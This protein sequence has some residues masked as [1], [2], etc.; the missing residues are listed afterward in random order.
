MSKPSHD[1]VRE[2]IASIQSN[3]RFLVATHVR[4]DGDAIGSVLS[5][6]RVLQRLGKTADPYCQDPVPAA[7]E[8]LPAVQS[9][10]NNATRPDLYDV[11]VL[12]DCGEFLRVGEALAESIRRIPFQ[13]SI[14]HHISYGS[15]G[16]VFWNKT[17]AS[18]TCEMLYELCQDLPLTIDA[19]L[20]TTLYTGLLSDTGSFRFSNT[21]QRVLEI[22]ANLVAAGAR[23]A[24]IA[25]QVYDSA[26]VQSLW[27]LAKVLA[28]L[29]FYSDDHLATAEMSQKMFSETR[30]APADAEGFVN[31]L[32]SVGTV[33]MAIL[34]R[35]GTDGDV[36][37]SL[38][39]K[40]DIDVADFAR[41]LG[42]GG[43]RNAAAFHVRGELGAT[44]AR[45]TGEALAFLEQETWKR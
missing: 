13:I 11:A 2:L 7:Y 29:A 14:D 27:L 9:I 15:F 30:A 26:S 6:T 3:Q 41:R 35:E 22:A 24:F 20:A 19:D 18:S 38:R 1:V 36:H 31:F 42:G 37:V 5:M 21:N 45:F 39:S 16:N 40:G 23:P 8:F 32:R 10:R 34:F 33:K 28:T 12:L 44:R 4:P 17:T 25:E 43:H